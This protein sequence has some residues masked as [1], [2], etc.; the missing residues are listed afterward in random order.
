MRLFGSILILALMLGSVLCAVLA[1]RQ[2]LEGSLV[3]EPVQLDFGKVNPSHL[4]CHYV[5]TNHEKKSITVL[6]VLTSCGCTVPT[7]SRGS[8][9]PG[10]ST[11]VDCDWNV[12][13]KAGRISM[14][15]TVVFTE[16]SASVPGNKILVL[17][18]TAEV[19]PRIN[20]SANS[21]SFPRDSFAVSTVDVKTLDPAWK[22]TEVYSDSPCLSSSVRNDG[23]QIRIE[24]D[25]TKLNAAFLTGEMRVVARTTCPQEAIILIP[26][27][28][29]P[30]TSQ[31]ASKYKSNPIS[32]NHFTLGEL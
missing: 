5:I 23:A 1:R 9:S 2:Y 28:V 15:A 8:L 12:D 26:V 11:A 17:A 16:E 4:K 21:I 19:N 3:G 6:S 20:L 29:L 18:A 30:S 22:V 7:F 13:G 25:P 27:N 31:P 24:F 14:T 10:K 32:E